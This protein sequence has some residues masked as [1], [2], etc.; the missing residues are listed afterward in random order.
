MDKER[1]LIIDDESLICE[2]VGKI[3]NVS[4]FDVSLATSGKEGLHKMYQV[5]PNL[6]LLDLMMPVMDGFEVLKRIRELT[7]VPVIVLSAISGTDAT[8]RALEIGADDFIKKP[9]EKDEL[10]AR[11]H[12]VLRRAIKSQGS[13]PGHRYHDDYLVI[14]LQ[15]HAVWVEGQQVRL[16]VTEFNFLEYLYLHSGK[17]CTYTGILENVWGNAASNRFQYIHVYVWKLRS[18]IEQDPD[19]PKYLLTE[20]GVGY[21]FVKRSTN[22]F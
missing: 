10:L 8:V 7:E 15:E 22:P 18:K 3:L 5:Q 9:F 16:T 20:H 2:V 11:V 4:G 19:H 13:I 12:S 1:I 21:R 6:V 14:D 17:V